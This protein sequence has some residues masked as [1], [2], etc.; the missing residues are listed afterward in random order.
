MLLSFFQS[1]DQTSMSWMRP[2]RHRSIADHGGGPE[3]PCGL[4]G[5][6]PGPFRRRGR[7]TPPG[8]TGEHP[9]AGCGRGAGDQVRRIT[10]PEVGRT[11]NPRD[12]ELM[13]FC[14][15][16]GQSWEFD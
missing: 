15:W 7:G 16:F 10:G 13:L 12:I 6:K 14:S 9:G 3:V 1:L 5:G 8:G 4:R 11:S 2:T